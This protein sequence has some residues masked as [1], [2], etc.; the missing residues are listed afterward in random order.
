VREVWTALAVCGVLAAI[1]V[2]VTMWK[3]HG[4]PSEVVATALAA[5]IFVVMALV[6]VIARV[7]S[8]RKL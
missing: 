3:I 1:A 5:V 8:S 7:E 4:G 2:T 6:V